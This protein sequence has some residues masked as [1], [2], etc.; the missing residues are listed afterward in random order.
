MLLQWPL[1]ILLPCLVNSASLGEFLL[2]RS[3]EKYAS[4]NEHHIPRVPNNRRLI[5]SIER[6]RTR[7]YQRNFDEDFVKDEPSYQSLEGETGEE[8]LLGGLEAFTARRPN[9]KQDAFTVEPKTGQS[10]RLRRDTFS[11][12][13]RN[14]R[15]NNLGHEA[16]RNSP[17]EP[18]AGEKQRVKRAS[19]S[20][21]VDE[22]DENSARWRRFDTPRHQ[23]VTS[24]TQPATGN[25]NYYSGVPQHRAE[26]AGDENEVHNTRYNEAR[27][28]QRDPGRYNNGYARQPVAYRHEGEAPRRIMYYATLPEINRGR[29]VDNIDYRRERTAYGDRY[30]Y[31][32]GYNKYPRESRYEG[33]QARPPPGRDGPYRH[34][35]AGSGGNSYS[36][37]DAERPL[38]QNAW[39]PPQ[40]YAHHDQDAM[41]R[42]NR[43][44]A[45]YQQ[46]QAGGRHAYDQR[47]GPIPPPPPPAE[48]PNAALHPSRYNPYGRT[49][50]L[51]RNQLTVTPS[52]PAV[53]DEPY[54]DYNPRQPAPWSMQIGTKLTVK[55]DGRQMPSPGGKRFYV[56]S[57]QEYPSRYLR[58][59]DESDMRH[60]YK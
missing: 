58:S 7:E 29:P 37:I 27:S 3:S 23:F 57:Q 49:G 1:L 36:I 26:Q 28:H 46:P 51:P 54:R 21:A 22:V 19:S 5:P 25:R 59:D 45:P 44:P 56:Q 52:N 39:P 50:S 47:R 60:I 14:I 17:E 41:S 24:R 13:P 10:L 43:I 2:P 48:G 38:P 15:G 42:Y 20:P 33:T 18:E 6:L 30:D 40:Q 9:L 16:F 55:D 12:E 32:R 4:P 35:Q 8:K 53:G 31:G 11:F 34:R